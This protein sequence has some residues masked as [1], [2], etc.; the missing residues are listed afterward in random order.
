MKHLPAKPQV[1]PGGDV[2]A[3]PRMV[4]DECATCPERHCLFCGLDGIADNRSWRRLERG[5]RIAVDRESC[6]RFWIVVSGVAALGASLAD[7]RRQIL[8]LEMPGDMVC[9]MSVGQGAEN[10]LEGLTPCQICEIDL[11]SGAAHLMSDAEFLA[12]LFHCVH[13]RVKDGTLTQL[14]LG[15]FDGLERV[16]L[17]LAA[18]A[19][20]AGT[21]RDGSIRVSIPMSRE[22]IADFLGLN[23]ETVSRLMSRIKKSGLVIFLSPTEYVVPDIARLEGRVPVALGLSAPDHDV[24]NAQPEWV[25]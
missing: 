23:A 8:S 2:H 13:R 11:R 17:F 1:A 3:P 6:L 5:D 19:R 10:W 12:R 18:M 9:G 15:R 14:A 16:C 22:D 4:A 20:R 7:G 24:A 25:Q 21:E